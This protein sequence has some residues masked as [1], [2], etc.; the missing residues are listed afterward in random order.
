MKTE[1]LNYK[2]NKSMKFAGSD[3]LEE[4]CGSAWTT[5]VLK[6]YSYPLSRSCDTL[7]SVFGTKYLTIYLS[8]ISDYLITI[9]I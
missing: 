5:C 1:L 6:K 7:N 3:C 2:R 4:I 8:I 9:I